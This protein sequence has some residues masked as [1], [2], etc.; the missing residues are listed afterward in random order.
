MAFT[1]LG[2]DYEKK[3]NFRYSLQDYMHQAFR[4]DDFKDK[5]VLD[6]GCGAGIDAAEFARNG[7]EVT[8]VDFTKKAVVLTQ[9]LFQEANIQGKILLADAAS[10]PFPDKSFDC[11]Y[12]FGVLHHIPEIE[13]VLGEIQ[14]VLKPN[15]MVMAMVYHR[16]SLLYAYLI[17]L[18]GVRQ[19][20][21][22]TM[23]EDK[24]FSRYS[25]RHEGNPYAYA[26]T[27]QEAKELF[28]QFFNNINISV[29]YNVID[30]L[31]QRKVKIGVPESFNLGYHL[32]IKGRR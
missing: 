28:K 12:S 10:L 19:G 4:F 5:K 29:H 31:K 22:K 30:T 27:Q 15:G 2:W 17:Y 16:D 8:A 9:E 32:V 24:I 7:A 23:S 11:V 20:L 14:R 13:K 18:Y 21:L 1:D 3:R 6:I 26:Y 25:E